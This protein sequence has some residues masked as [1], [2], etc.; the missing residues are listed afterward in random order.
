VPESRLS[1]FASRLP[2]HDADRLPVPLARELI[3]SA[4]HSALEPVSE[5]ERLPLKNALGRVLAD[6]VISF[7]N[8]PAHDNSAMD[9]YALCGSH[10]GEQ[11]VTLRIIGA[12]YAGRPYGGL[13][14]PGECIRIMTGA[15]MPQGC[16]TV[17]PN[18]FVLTETDTHVTLPSGKI[19]AGDNR[20][21]AGEDL[22]MGSAAVAQGKIL[23]PADLG[24]IA[25]LG[26]G[27]INV[28]RR[29]RVAYFSTGDELRSPGE[30]LDEGCVYDSNRYTLHGMLLRM[31]CEPIDMG[32]VKDDPAALET[33]LRKACG[34]ADAI[35]TS[36]GV[37]AGDADYT[38]NMMTR[39]G[40]VLFWKIEMRPGRPM[41]FGHIASGTDSAWLFGLPGNPV[42][43]MVSFYFFA[44]DALYQL[45]GATPPDA[46]AVTV[47]SLENLRKK[48]GRTEYQ[49]GILSTDA[50]GVQSVRITGAQGS[51]I[52][53]S[54]S[55]AN[56]MVILNHDQGD[57]KA[58]DPVEVMP[59]HGLL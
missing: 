9:G 13:V 4:V 38:R 20:R 48:P 1:E 3:R 27:D 46:L 14:S 43:T 35:I 25:S 49:R 23:T 19:N 17:M 31:G 28:R 32:V 42:A 18:E 11:P 15:V 58:G 6:D 26:I 55:Q 30:P 36:G 33:A 56:C 57:V 59:F 7:I 8:V 22:G 45:M 37:S 52:L 34:M 29:L 51:G 53:S 50:R 5:S 10:L 41:A 39:L 54:M 47:P 40:E 2:D 16:D 12:A 24:L 21:L 44:R